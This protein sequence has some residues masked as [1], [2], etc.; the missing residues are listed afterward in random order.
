M[1]NVVGSAMLI[2][3]LMGACS[4]PGVDPSPSGNPP[5]PSDSPGP[6]VPDVVGLSLGPARSALEAA[7]LAVEVV[8]GSPGGSIV[9]EQDPEAGAVAVPGASVTITLDE[10]ERRDVET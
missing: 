7:G 2:A 1:T 4:S 6:L 10:L 5:V 8:Q 3:L 9:V